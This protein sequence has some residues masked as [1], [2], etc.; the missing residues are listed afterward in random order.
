[1]DRDLCGQKVGLTGPCVVESGHVT[2]MRI[3]FSPSLLKSL[4]DELEGIMDPWLHVIVSVIRLVCARTM[5]E[6]LGDLDRA[7]LVPVWSMQ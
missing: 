2:S 3:F 1:V 4:L 6:H 5:H 7:G